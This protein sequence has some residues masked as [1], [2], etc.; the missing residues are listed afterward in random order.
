M[1][2]A[3]GEPSRSPLLQLIIWLENQTWL[4]WLVS[5]SAQP[6]H[7]VL[8]FLYRLENKLHPIN[9]W[10]DWQNRPQPS[11][12]IPLTADD[13]PVETRL[14]DGVGNYLSTMVGTYVDA[15][16]LSK[17]LPSGTSLDPAHIHNGEHALIMLFGYTEDLH[18]AWWPF[19]SMNYLEFVLAVPHIRIDDDVEYVSRFFYIPTLHL[20]RFYPVILGW[21]V[22]YRKK[23]SRVAATNNTYT[24]KSLFRG[25]PLLHAEFT[26]LKLQG[27]EKTEHWKELCEE[28]H[29]N[30]FGDDK[31]FLHFHWDWL[32]A[33]FEPVDATVTLYQDFPGHQSRRLHLQGHGHGAME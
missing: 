23:W 1:P 26:S 5:F 9:L 24:I 8:G 28:P 30:P 22:G 7:A 6:V 10:K 19:R 12:P 2:K 13:L 20:N 4:H 17:L 18:F 14:C 27:R 31:L 25:R 21:M 32:R 3:P 15:D 16:N 29:L 11:Y 33:S